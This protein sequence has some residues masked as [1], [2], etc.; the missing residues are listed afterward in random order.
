MRLRSRKLFAAP[1]GGA[2]ASATLREVSN[3]LGRGQNR[4]LL[5]RSRSKPSTLEGGV[6]GMIRQSEKRSRG[7]PGWKGIKLGAEDGAPAEETVVG[8]VVMIWQQQQLTR[9]RK[10][11]ERT[12]FDIMYLQMVVK[13]VLRG[14]PRVLVVRQRIGSSRDRV[15]L[16]R[17]HSLIKIISATI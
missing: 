13:R 1:F 15:W 10:P 17:N 16:Q 5:W 7:S 3:G 14:W 12:C 6:A 8:K 2:E 11:L 4:L 9:K